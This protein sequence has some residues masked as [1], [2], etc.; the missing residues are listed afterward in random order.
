MS[1]AIRS[2][3]DLD[4]WKAGRDVRLF[5]SR[6]VLPQLPKEERYRLGDQVLRAGRR[7]SGKLTERGSADEA[8]QGE[9]GQP[10]GA[11]PKHRGSK[12]ITRSV[13]GLGA[14][15]TLVPRL[16]RRAAWATFHL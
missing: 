5:V 9:D 15:W 2:F 10:A 1:G 14:V 3:E 16:T 11:A 13:G 12:A 7:K 4:C 8:R 6:D